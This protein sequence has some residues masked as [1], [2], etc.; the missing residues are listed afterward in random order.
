MSL[1]WDGHDP[2]QSRPAGRRVRNLERSAQ[3]SGAFGKIAESAGAG[4]WS[5]TDAVI[6]NRHAQGRCV[7]FNLDE[8][9]AGVG[10]A[11]DVRKRF[12]DAGDGVRDYAARDGYL[13]G[14]VEF[15]GRIESQCGAG[16]SNDVQDLCTQIEFVVV[17]GS[18]AEDRVAD[19]S[20]DLVEDV[21]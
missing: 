11:S 19:L 6:R 5:N 3:E 21:N 4:V 2:L 10:V 20:N 1:T 17:L 13:F 16:L 15:D 14:G 8:G 7:N 18:E 12:S 9:V